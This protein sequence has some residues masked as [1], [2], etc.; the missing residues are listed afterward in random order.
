M[1]SVDKPI[2]HVPAQVVVAILDWCT[3]PELVALNLAGGRDPLHLAVQ[4]PL[5]S[6]VRMHCALNV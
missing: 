6:L 3:W 4:R 5:T 1:L 2:I